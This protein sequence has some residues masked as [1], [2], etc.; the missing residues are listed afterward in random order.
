MAYASFVLL[1]F[2][3]ILFA[4]KSRNRYTW[5]FGLLI[6]SLNLM[7]ASLLSATAKIGNYAAPIDDGVFFY[8]QQLYLHLTRLFGSYQDIFRIGNIGAA[9]F[10]YSVALFALVSLSKT[11]GYPPG[12]RWPLQAGIAVF[13]ILYLAVFSPEAKYLAYVRYFSGEAGRRPMRF[14]LL[15]AGNLLM[16]LLLVAYLLFPIVAFALSRRFASSIYKRQQA[17][18]LGVSIVIL[19]IVF[20]FL[21]FA[22]PVKRLFA[23]EADLQCVLLNQAWTNASLFIVY[24]VL[25]F[26]IVAAM[27]IMLTTL[28]FLGG[29]SSFANMI[30]RRFI[31]RN[32]D[33]NGS[34]RGVFHSFKNVFF[35]YST[36]LAGMRESCADEETARRIELLERLNGENMRNV[37]TAL[38]SLR[39]PR[40][41]L[42]RTDVYQA[43]GRAVTGL[44]GVPGVELRLPS[45]RGDCHAFFSEF[46]LVE[47]FTNLLRNAQEAIAASGRSDGVVSVEILREDN[48]VIAR[49]ADNGIGIPANIRRRIFEPFFS[50]KKR[51]GRNWGLGLSF[52]AKSVA[53][54]GGLVFVGSRPGEGS[55]FEVLMY[56]S[57]EKDRA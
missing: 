17:V 48:T 30:P 7:I 5:L 43:L 14:F 12:R 18:L 57:K 8:D 25:P 44:E 34:L 50:T 46:Q 19:E 21:Y 54:H 38:D 36:I 49:V 35:S 51:S 3:I 11:L 40:Q 9:A 22:G 55:V 15:S 4:R 45:P 52:V 56:A 53:A 28:L 24:S 1:A 47:I 39:S 13:P 32:S 23:D 27:L 37:A 26:V 41:Y 29:L 31:R 42:M 20:A 33:D 6:V 2:W 10:V 16:T